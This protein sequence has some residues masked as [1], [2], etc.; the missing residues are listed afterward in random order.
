MS[1]VNTLHDEAMDLASFAMMERARG[2]SEKASELF[3]LALEK[4]LDA[5]SELRE[6]VEPSFSVLHRSAASLALDCNQFRKAEQLVAKA[7]AEEPPAEIAEELRYVWEQATFQRRLE[8]APSSL[9]GSASLTFSGKPVVGSSGIMADF[10]AK[11]LAAFEKAIASVGASEHGPLNWMGPIPNRDDYRLV[12]TN[13]AYGSFG[14][15]VEGASHRT[16]LTSDYSQVDAAIDRV[17]NI[18]NASVEADDD[19]EL[20]DLIGNIDRRAIKDVSEFLQIVADSEAVCSLKFEGEVFR[21]R[22]TY[23]VE[24]SAKRL[25]R[26][27]NEE[28]IELV[29]HFRGFL[30]SSRRAEFSVE[31]TGEVITGPVSSSISDVIERYLNESVTITVRRRQME[32]GKPHY[33]ILDVKV[34]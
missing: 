22:D 24:R 2:N 17:K 18:M 26:I 33:T 1:A 28:D 32:G 29:G 9:G 14:F 34:Y 19:Y 3:E 12:I 13:I 23:Q 21:Y 11:V 27:R 25:G 7:L 5:I 30:P 15:E 20:I 4:E 8:E 31:S 10:V 16:G 6:P